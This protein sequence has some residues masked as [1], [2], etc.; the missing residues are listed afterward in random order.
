VVKYDSAGSS[1]WAF[2]DSF[3]AGIVSSIAEDGS[4][5]VYLTGY[6]SGLVMHLRITDTLYRSTSGFSDV[7]VA[8][9]R[10][11]NTWLL[12]QQILRWKMISVYSR[13]PMMAV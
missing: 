1:V 13:Y 11:P 8:K 5:N 10:R 4:N 6:F 12:K 7:F 2:V 9:L 3:P